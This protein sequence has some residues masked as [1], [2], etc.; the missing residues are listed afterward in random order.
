VSALP[1]RAALAAAIAARLERERDA[2]A[3]VFAAARPTRY[4]VVDDVLPPAWTAAA[5]AAFPAPETLLLRSSLRERKRVGVDLERYA[6]IVGDLVLAFQEPSVV[7]A[8]QAI[9]GRAGLEAD[10]TLYASGISVMGRDDFLEPHLDNSHDGDQRRYRALNLLFYVAPGWQSEW[11]G[12]LEL[13]PPDFRQPVVIPAT[14]NRLVIME[15]GP[16]SWHSVDCVR[17]DRAR[18]C[19]SNYYFAPTPTGGAAY[20]HVTTF[21]GRPGTGWRRVVL[22]ADAWLRNTAGRLFPALVRRT[23]HRR[24]AERA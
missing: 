16:Q 13:W 2:A 21:A 10:P 4:V 6:P 22:G 5:A 8:V 3:A 7:A 20:R 18:L 9:T 11:G 24:A 14:C 12:N 17:V 15:T 1:D 19:V 23:R